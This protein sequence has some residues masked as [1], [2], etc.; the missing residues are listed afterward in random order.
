MLTAAVSRRAAESFF[1]LD[2][3]GSYPSPIFWPDL[4]AR[5]PITPRHLISRTA[6]GIAAGR[7]PATTS[8]SPCSSK[9]LFF[10]SLSVLSVTAQVFTIT[11]SASSR[12]AGRWPLS[13]RAEAKASEFPRFAVQP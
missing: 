9:S 10:I 2:L 12:D 3:S 1:L 13:R 7:H 5:T 6:A 11:R 8:R 4:L